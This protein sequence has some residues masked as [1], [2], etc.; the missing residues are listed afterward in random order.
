[1]SALLGIYRDVAVNPNWPLRVH[2][3]GR[4]GH[5]LSH[6]CMGTSR[7]THP[8][9]CCIGAHLGPCCP[10]LHWRH[11]GPHTGPPLTHG[12]CRVLGVHGCSWALGHMAC[13]L[14]A[15]ASMAACG[16]APMA[17]HGKVCIY[18][19]YGSCGSIRAWSDTG[20]A[21]AVVCRCPGLQKLCIKWMKYTF[22]VR[23]GAHRFGCEARPLIAKLMSDVNLADNR[24]SIVCHH[25]HFVSLHILTTKPWYLGL[26]YPLFW[27][28]TENLA[29]N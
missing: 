27:H 6:V 2:L 1:M 22:N 3:P 5:R 15:R 9:T 26:I 4:P 29:L 11:A 21:T 19:H 28:W 12:P 16:H 25:S 18:I 20:P 17:W 23:G 8:I 7:A 14:L 24:R 10:A 13:Y